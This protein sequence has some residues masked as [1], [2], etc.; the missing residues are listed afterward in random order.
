MFNSDIATLKIYL[1]KKNSIVNNVTDFLSENL[2][3][4][5]MTVLFMEHNSITSKLSKLLKSEYKPLYNKF[6]DC[7]FKYG[8]RL[9]L[10]SIK[11]DIPKNLYIQS[12]KI[13]NFQCMAYS[14]LL[15]TE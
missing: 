13:F 4:K 9:T 2:R 14:F 7:F 3:R 8:S 6:Q 1:N 5:T 11:Y 12:Q 15:I 10:Q